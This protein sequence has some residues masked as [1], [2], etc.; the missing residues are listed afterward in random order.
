MPL[1]LTK[2]K[3]MSFPVNAPLFIIPTLSIRFLSIRLR[4]TSISEC[5][6][7]HLFHLHRMYSPSAQTLCV[8]LVFCTV[9]SNQD[10]LTL[11]TSILNICT[12]K[13]RIRIVHL[14]SIPGIPR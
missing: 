3:S 6:C 11:K 14:E 13:A 8:R 10:L 9:T 7:T 2:C 1:N 4:H 5:T 12:A